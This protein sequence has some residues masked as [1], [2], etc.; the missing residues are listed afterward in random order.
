LSCYYGSNLNIPYSLANPTWIPAGSAVNLLISY[1]IITHGELNFMLRPSLS[2]SV[3]GQM[4]AWDATTINLAQGYLPYNPGTP[5]FITKTT[6]V[7]DFIEVDSSFLNSV[8]SWPTKD[9]TN[10]YVSWSVS[11]TSQYVNLYSVD[12]NGNFI[13]PIAQNTSYLWNN[14]TWSIAVTGYGPQTTTIILSSQRYNQTTFVSTVSSLFDYFAENTILV[15]PVVALDNY[16]YVRTT[17]LQAL[18]PYKGRTY[19]LPDNTLLNWT[20][21]Y[22]FNSTYNT[23]PIS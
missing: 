9:L 13:Q 20:W 16:N 18:V 11:P 17:T 7:A 21:A 6:E 22:N 8:S 15:T 14:Q 4:D 23:I 2:S 5:I 1:P 3:A 10:S 19:N 12:V